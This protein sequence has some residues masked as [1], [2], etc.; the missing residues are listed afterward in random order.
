MEK[1]GLNL[2][3]IRYNNRKN[4]YRKESEYGIILH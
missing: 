4:N 2:A 3:L 1:T